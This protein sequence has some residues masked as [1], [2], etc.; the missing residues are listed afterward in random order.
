MHWSYYNLAPSHWCVLPQSLLCCVQYCVVLDHDIRGLV[1]DCSISIANALELLQ[2]CTKPSIWWDR[3]T[4]QILMV[5]FKWHLQT[6][7]VQFYSILFWPQGVFFLQDFFY[8]PF[9]SI[10]ESWCVW[11]NIWTENK[12]ANWCMTPLTSNF[13]GILPKGPYLPCVSMAG[14]ALLAG[15]HRLVARWY[16]IKGQVNSWEI[17]LFLT[18]CVSLVLFTIIDRCL[19]QT[20]WWFMFDL[21]TDIVDRYK[22]S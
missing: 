14:R 16:L 15:Y 3:L 21:C 10:G 12:S 7:V 22:R 1:Q 2:S 8:L 17:C 13:Q 18:F 5:A 6:T 9:V 20:W 4:A 11:L 19:M